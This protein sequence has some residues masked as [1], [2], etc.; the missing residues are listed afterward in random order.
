MILSEK[1]KFVFVKPNKIGGTTITATLEELG[2]WQWTDTTSDQMGNHETYREI[3]KTVKNVD[4]YFVFSFVRNPWARIL[5]YYFYVTG[6]EIPR[7]QNNQE[8]NATASWA[9]SL[10]PDAIQMYTNIKKAKN[11]KGALNFLKLK[12]FFNYFENTD[13]EIN[14]DFI[15]KTENLQEDFN[16]VCDKIGI[17]Q[18]QLPHKNK[19]KHKHYTE[20]Y[21]EETKQIVAEKYAKDIETFGYEFGE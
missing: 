20:Y 11:F 9:Q 16:T 12:S 10:K 18:K 14:L 6:N 15:G 2:V 19:S 4:D 17:P 3:T 7:K 5:S 1:H 21:D 13:G 8:S